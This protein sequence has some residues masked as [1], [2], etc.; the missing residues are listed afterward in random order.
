MITK[1]ALSKSLQFQLATPTFDYPHMRMRTHVFTHYIL[2]YDGRTR[3]VEEERSFCP[4]IQ[5][6]GCHIE[7]IPW[8]ISFT[9]KRTVSMEIPG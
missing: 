5:L 6:Q 8:R 9:R 3:K 1:E 2:Y 4:P 7:E